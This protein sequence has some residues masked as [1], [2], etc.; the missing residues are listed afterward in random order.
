MLPTHRSTT[1]AFAVFTAAAVVATACTN[2]TEPTVLSPNDALA[3]KGGAN[4]VLT[5]PVGTLAQ[6]VSLTSLPWGIAVSPRGDVLT[7]LPFTNSVAGFSLS[8]PTVARP[9][10]TVN[11]YPLDVIFD[12]NGSTAYVGTRDGGTVDVVDIRTNTVTQSIPLGPDVYRLALSRDESRVYATTL[13]GRLWTARTHGDPRPTYV[14]LTDPWSPVQGKSLSPSGSDLYIA[15]TNGTIWRLDPV[16]LAVRQSIVLPRQIQDIAATPDGSAVWAADE[17]GYVVRLDPMTLAVTATVNL[18][19]LGGMPFGLAI[20]PDGARIYAAS[21]R[22]GQLFIIA[23]T[24]P[25]TFG[26]TPIAIGGTPRRIGFGEN[27]A[28]AVVSNEANWVDIVR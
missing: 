18:A 28:V 16:T 6:R 26:I 23:E 12:K 19:A 11:A 17:N 22:S 2:V 8:N 4:V 21:S 24:A 13:R 15:S 27:G 20:S 9:P 25:N 3:A 1:R 10:V 7:V 14:D 5:H